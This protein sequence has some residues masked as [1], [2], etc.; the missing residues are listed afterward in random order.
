LKSNKELSIVSLV[1]LFSG[2]SNITLPTG[3]GTANEDAE[4]ASETGS[5]L[6]VLG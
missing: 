3:S 4:G 6:F 5:S 2:S 1:I